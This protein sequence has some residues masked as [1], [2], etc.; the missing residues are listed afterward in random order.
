MMTPNYST[1]DAALEMVL[2]AGPD[3]TNGLTS[4]ASM[5]A[6][7]MCSM[8]RADAVISWVENYR[9]MFTDRPRPSVKIDMNRWRDAL[10]VVNRFADWVVF[11]QNE[12]RERRWVEVIRQWGALL[13]PGLVGAAT[14]GIIRTGHAVRALSQQET[15]ARVAELAEGLAYWAATYEELPEKRTSRPTSLPSL[16]IDS[17]PI[18]P[19]QRRGHFHTIVEALVQLDDFPAF[20]ETISMVETGGSAPAFISDLTETFARIYLTNAHDIITT[21]ALIHAVDAPA[22]LRHISA[23]L[24]TGGVREGLSFAWQASAS[25]YS[26]Y[27]INPPQ[28][29]S[30]AGAAADPAELF[31]H[32]IDAGDEHA[33]KFTE[34]CLREHAM[35]PKPCY[36][37]AARHAIG[38][39]KAI[40]KV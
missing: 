11:F 39:L 18:L 8:G 9:H 21:I 34:V 5:G 23:Y 16:A 29:D 3:L 26:I 27:G 17:V 13:S 30:V 14:H 19:L 7:A 1:M 36:L 35:N 31:Q 28:A 33:I 22:A 10:G 4:H 15:P 32:A 20:A 37:E 2:K 12:L 25:L 40:G 24:D 38:V 6:E